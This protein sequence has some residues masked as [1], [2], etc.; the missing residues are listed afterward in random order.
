MAPVLYGTI[1]ASRAALGA[2]MHA[3]QVALRPR[4][5]ATHNT[6]P[7][8]HPPHVVSAGCRLTSN[9]N[10]NSVYLNRNNSCMMNY[11]I[12]PHKQAWT[13]NDAVQ[14]GPTSGCCHAHAAGHARHVMYT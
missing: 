11:A 5:K 6:R 4:T 13:T 1:S 14:H 12:Y 2:G 3:W 9:R 8:G 10:C 7:R